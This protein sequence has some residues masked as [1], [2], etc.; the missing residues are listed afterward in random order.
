[1][2]NCYFKGKSSAL[3]SFFCLHFC[4]LSFHAVKTHWMLRCISCVYLSFL[5]SY[6]VWIVIQNDLFSFVM[7]GLACTFQRSSV[8]AQSCGFVIAFAI[9]CF[10]QRAVCGLLFAFTLQLCLLLD[11]ICPFYANKPL[12][13]IYTL[14]VMPCIF[15]Y[16]L[17]KSF[18]HVKYSISIVQ[19]VA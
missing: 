1:M 12:F 2:S 9:L 3:T 19:R 8:F 4:R 15:F 16:M 14:L 13:L 18:P 11:D 10:L 5:P 7:Y 17:I 6:L